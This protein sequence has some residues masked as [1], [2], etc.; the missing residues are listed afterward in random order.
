MRGWV[1]ASS[2]S[3]WSRQAT[4]NLHGIDLSAGMLEAARGKNLYRELRRMTL[5]EPLDFES[6]LFDA[7]VSVGVFTTGHAPVHA[8]D[9]LLRI[10]KPGGHI[11]FSLKAELREADFG[12]YLAQL[13]SAGK[14]RLVERSDPYH[15]MPKGEP[16]V[17]HHISVYRVT[18]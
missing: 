18:S 2:A 7:V 11:V 16:T 10:T 1:R 6:D 17:V 15:P 4:G 5:G 12:D 8:F 3:V 9:E 13:E 14:W